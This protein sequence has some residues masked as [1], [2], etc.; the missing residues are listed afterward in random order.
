L[1]WSTPYTSSR[2]WLRFAYIKMAGTALEAIKGG[3]PTF[4]HT[5]WEKKKRREDST[6]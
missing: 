4:T 1:T 3:L 2:L 6:F 5:I